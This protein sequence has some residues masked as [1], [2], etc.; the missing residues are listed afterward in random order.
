MQP[1]KLVPSA[2]A[3]VAFAAGASGEGLYPFVTHSFAGAEK[4]AVGIIRVG[5][6]KQFARMA[7]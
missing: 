5:A 3:G 4:G 7:H 6:P 2:V 1:R